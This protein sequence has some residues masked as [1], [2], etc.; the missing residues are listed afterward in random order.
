MSTTQEGVAETTLAHDPSDGEAA[1]LAH[2]MK[3]DPDAVK[4][5]EKSEP[6]GDDKPRDRR[7]PVED[8]TEEPETDET[9]EETPEETEEEGE[10]DEEEPKSKKYVDDDEVYAKVK[11]GDTEHEVPVSQ[12]KRLYGQEASLTQKSQ[13]LA[14]KAKEVESQSAQYSTGIQALLTRAIER[15]KPYANLDF[16]TLS[17]SDITAEQLSA[18]RDEAQQRI[19]EVNFLQSELGNYQKAV[20]ERQHAA[21]VTQAK[22]TVKVLSDPASEHYIEGWNQTVYNDIRNYAIKEGLSADIANNL[23]DAP[24]IKLLHKAMRYD[25]GV[26]NVKTVVKNK[27]VK[28]VIK[29]SSTMPTAERGGKGSAVTKAAAK[30][31]SSGSVDDAAELFLARFKDAE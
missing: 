19:E 16:L 10:G 9:S 27:T 25:A 12:L 14:T 29:T 5:S 8:D 18:L 28:K 31:K 7:T 17:K 11:V 21:L 3:K 15:A 4:P 6:L 2:F 24:A 26:K 1:F 13:A 23:V 22:E 20:G 30:L